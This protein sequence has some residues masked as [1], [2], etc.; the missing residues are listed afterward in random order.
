[1]FFFIPGSF[2]NTPEVAEAMSLD[3]VPAQRQ[4]QGKFGWGGVSAAASVSN[5]QKCHCSVLL[6]PSSGTQ[7]A[8]LARGLV[9]S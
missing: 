2:R 1:M 7:E 9:T 5:S 3:A 4:E 8:C 6:T